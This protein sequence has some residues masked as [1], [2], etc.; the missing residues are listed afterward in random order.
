M[1]I[2][3]TS[4]IC[5]LGIFS[6]AFSVLYGEVDSSPVQM[7]REYVSVRDFSGTADERINAAI[8]EAMR[9]RHKTV[10]LPNGTYP[11]RDTIL[12]NRG[13][14]SEVHLVGESRKGVVLIPDIAYLEANYKG[15]NGAKLAHMINLTEASVFDSLNVS[16]QN[17]TV[18]MKAQFL[19]RE[20]TTYTVVGHGIRVGQGWRSGQFK[21]N[22]VTIRNTPGYGI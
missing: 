19:S 12:L 1:I 21:V 2:L 20:R 6:L 16:I 3:R 22:Q 4:I 14:N 7:P 15:G 17:L 8:T 10:L 18:D 11:L 5:F 9:T 13:K